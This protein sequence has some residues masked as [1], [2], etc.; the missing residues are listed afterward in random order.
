MPVGPPNRVVRHSVEGVE[1]SI[2]A[3]DGRPGER[4]SATGTSASTSP[5]AGRAP[6]RESDVNTRVLTSWA[7]ERVIRPSRRRSRSYGDAV[8]VDREWAKLFAAIDQAR[9]L[10]DHV[11]EEFWSDWLAERAQALRAFG[12][13]GIE[14]P[15]QG[16]SGMG[17]FNDLLVHRFNGH[18][19]SSGDEDH[20][21]ARLG[22]LRAE[23][24]R[25]AER[26]RSNTR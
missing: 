11:G 13:N 12:A 21:N 1:A 22:E 4:R 9:D 2:G 5:S 26:I 15:L 17:S 8:D 25:T 6:A 14:R 19:V 20:V 3:G 16:F 18:R 23:I 7:R 10:L 24:F